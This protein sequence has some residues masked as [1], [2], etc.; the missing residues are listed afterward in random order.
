G[1][2]GKI[3]GTGQTNVFHPMK[4]PM[5]VQTLRGL[6]NSGAMHW[7]GDRSNGPE[8]DNATNETIS[9]ENFIDAFA[10]L[11]NGQPLSQ[12]DMQTF[13]NFQL[14]VVLPPNPVRSLDN[15]LNTAQQAGKN[16]FAG[17]R[18][19]DGVNL[20]VLGV[21]LGQTAFTCNGCH[22]LDPAE[23]QFGTST[24]ASFEGIQQI[25]KIPHLRNMYTKV[26]MFGFPRVSFF[27]NVSTAN[28]GNQVRGFGFT[29]EGSVDTVFHFVNAVVFNPTIN[30]GFPLINPDATR[31]NV[32]QF[33]L[34]FDSDLAPI[35]GQ[36]VT[37]NSTNSSSVGP[38]ITLME[39]RC[40]TA[41]TSKVLGGTTTEC[42]L[43]ATVVLNG[44]VTGFL[45]DPTSGNFF[46]SAGVATS[47]TALRAL[48]GTA[49]QEVQFT[50]TTPG[51][52]SRLAFSSNSL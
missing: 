34:A 10:S 35:V 44:A 24:N 14:Q 45:F 40:G 3:N 52:G 38:R 42:D 12:A 48:A 20:G 37:L 32:E 26:G 33:V 47:D 16:F 39:Q 49:G 41:F 15:S 23:G 30:S 27:N 8:G 21:I 18:P 28:L 51:S 2:P 17:N 9:F 22:E 11:M 50:A 7:R 6:A 4:G 43:V 13:T 46:N 19:A 25:F 31:R 36:Q 29:N 5:T 1:T